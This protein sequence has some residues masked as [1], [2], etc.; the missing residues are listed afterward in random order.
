MGDHDSYDVITFV[1]DGERNVS[2]LFSDPSLD[3]WA[4]P[5][6]TISIDEVPSLIG[7]IDEVER[8]LGPLTGC[9]D[10]CGEPWATSPALIAQ[11]CEPRCRTSVSDSS[12]VVTAPS[13]HS[14]PG[15]VAN[16]S[17]TSTR[18]RHVIVVMV[19]ALVAGYFWLSASQAVIDGDEPHYVVVADSLVHHHTLDL[20]ASYSDPN[21]VRR[22]VPGIRPHVVTRSDG[23]AYPWPQGIGL[24]V[25]IVPAWWLRHSFRA[26]RLELLL[27]GRRCCAPSCGCSLMM[28]AV[29]VAPEARF[30]SPSSLRCRWLRS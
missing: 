12:A 1:G 16:E 30:G 21:G 23:R 26:V 3:L 25:L 8:V 11:L 13:E 7:Q 20:R 22:F 19:V 15:G 18:W 2:V 24:P 29:V 9:C 6:T 28:S 5:V 10:A 4:M 17:G 14:R 27:I